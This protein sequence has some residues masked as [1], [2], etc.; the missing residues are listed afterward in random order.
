[1]WTLSFLNESGLIFFR[2]IYQCPAQRG[3]GNSALSPRTLPYL[4]FPSGLYP[5]VMN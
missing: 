3:H 1:M 2:D 5:F 4:S